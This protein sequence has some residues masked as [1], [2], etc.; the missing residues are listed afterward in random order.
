MGIGFSFVFARE[1]VQ[2]DSFIPQSYFF[3]VM[4]YLDWGISSTFVTIRQPN[5]L[6][7]TATLFLTR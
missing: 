3:Y 2:F 7:V 6:D 5:V 4:V 1:T